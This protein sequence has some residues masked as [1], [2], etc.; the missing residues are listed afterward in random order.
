MDSEDILPGPDGKDYCA[1]CI[2]EE[3]EDDE[4]YAQPAFEAPKPV[5]KQR[6]RVARVRKVTRT[7]QDDEVIVAP[8]PLSRADRERAEFE[9]QARRTVRVRTVTTIR[10][11]D[12]GVVAPRPFTRQP[13]RVD[14]EQAEHEEASSSLTSRVGKFFTR[15]A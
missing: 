5:K 14:R 11:D 2:P 10:P 6:E 12:E 7:H 15:N 4:E 8:R 3:L 1:A 13:T 9:P